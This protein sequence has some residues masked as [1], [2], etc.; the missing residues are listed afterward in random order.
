MEYNFHELAK[1]MVLWEYAI[2]MVGGNARQWGLTDNYNA[3][4]D[5]CRMIMR[6]YGVLVV[7]GIQFWDRLTSYRTGKERYHL[8]SNPETAQ[9]MKDLVQACFDLVTT[10]QFPIPWWNANAGL[11]WPSVT[12][13]F[14]AVERQVEE[15]SQAGQSASAV[16]YDAPEDE[17]PAVE[18]DERDRMAQQHQD[19]VLSEHDGEDLTPRRRQAL[20]DADASEQ[21]LREAV[22][23]DAQV[24]SRPEGV[25]GQTVASEPA[26]AAYGSVGVAEAAAVPRE[27]EA[28][29]EA[30]LLTDD[31]LMMYPASS[32]AEEERRMLQRGTSEERTAMLQGRLSSARGRAELARTR[33]EA[34]AKELAVLGAAGGGAAY[35][36]AAPAAPPAVTVGGEAS[37]ADG[38]AGMALPIRPRGSI[39]DAPMGDALP[40]TPKAVF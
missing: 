14:A 30:F 18:P 40:T 8:S 34:R 17:D 25:V 3:I 12:Q 32:Y 21:V 23:A 5:R 1:E 16:E 27:G 22:A 24:A 36:S 39:A 13:H 31:D 10:I 11:D 15:E 2:A 38:G 33:E 9:G 35:G 29:Q 4:A 28:Q 20:L 19:E 26:S 6:S 7:D 37:A